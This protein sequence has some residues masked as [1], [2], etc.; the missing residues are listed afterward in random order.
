MGI[1][2][3]ALVLVLMSGR[4]L[5]SEYDNSSPVVGSCTWSEH[6]RGSATVLEIDP[7]TGTEFAYLRPNDELNDGTSADNVEIRTNR[8]N[9]T[10]SGIVTAESYPI[11]GPVLLEGGCRPG[12]GSGCAKW[13][14]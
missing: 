2:R 5:I 10:A 13:Y 9:L 6:K 14:P 4:L 11:E 12:S 1:A 3:E 8:R 7:R